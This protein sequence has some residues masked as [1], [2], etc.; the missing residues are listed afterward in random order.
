M[1]SEKCVSALDTYHPEKIRHTKLKAHVEEIRTSAE[2]GETIT[3][4]AKRFG[5]SF[6]SVKAIVLGESYPGDSWKAL[7]IVLALIL[8]VGCSNARPYDGR[9]RID[10]ISQRLPVSTRVYGCPRQ[11]TMRCDD[12]RCWCQPE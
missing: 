11:R 2:R 3:E 10:P 8:L 1:D 6:H 7:G 5:A 9:P 12:V 4:L